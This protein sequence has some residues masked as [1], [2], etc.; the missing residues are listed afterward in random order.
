[1]SSPSASRAPR[2]HDIVRID[3]AVLT[4]ASGQP[5]AWAA[6]ALSRAP[7]AVVRR[8]TAPA[9]MLSVGIRGAERAQRWPALYPLAG[10]SEVH[11][12]ED[13]RHRRTPDAPA[14]HALMLLR[15]RWESHSSEWGPTGSAGFEL[16]TGCLTV[17]RSSDLDLVLRAD[18][19]LSMSS[20]AAML[21]ETNGLPVAVDIR[22]ETPFCGFSLYEF[23]RERSRRI[24]LRHPSLVVIGDDPWRK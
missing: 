20:A 19:P 17:T 15:D 14:F 9:G 12:P 3:P 6:D 11:R 18:Q 7:F 13:L 23:V 8:S 21:A 5:P 2:V 22:V 16:A 24:L 1:M 4:S 10:I